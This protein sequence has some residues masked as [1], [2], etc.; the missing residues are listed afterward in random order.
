MS[1][2]FRRAIRGELAN[3]AGAVFTVLFSIVFSVSLVRI[4]GEAAGG[5]VDDQAVFSIV[6]LSALTSLPTL[7]TLTVFV[8]ILLSL[9][10]A[11]RDSEMVVWFAS[12]LSLVAWVRPVLRFAA[13]LLVAIALLSLF[14]APWAN[15]QIAESRDRFA[16]R[17]DVTRLAPGRFIESPGSERVIFVETV[18]LE[19]GHV[20]NVFVSHRTQNRDGVTVAAQGVIETQPD[21]TRYLVLLNGRRY[22]GTPGRPEYRV[23][24]F[25]RYALRLDAQPEAPLTDASMR[26]R[27]TPELVARFNRFDQAEMLARVAAPIVALVLAL[28]AI[29]LAHANPRGVRSANLIFAVM[30]FLLYQNGLEIVQSLVMRERMPFV[31]A[32]WI[33]HAVAGA[34]VVVLFIRRVHLQRWLPQW[35]ALPENAG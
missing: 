11:H 34:L 25:E 4:L 24:E 28:L 16:K 6:A 35:R 21:G 15:H 29:P 10:R 12:G 23:L 7:L 9:T 1:N 8:A 27:S 13:P 2:V 30:L 3:S 5:R 17:D 22:E 32:L 14:V 18:D 20:R 31:T 33:V 26:A 19:S